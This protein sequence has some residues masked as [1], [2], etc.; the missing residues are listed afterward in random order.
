[1]LRRFALIAAL[2]SAL[3][4]GAADRPRVVVVK[5]AA[6]GPYAQVMAGFSAE[7]K[8]SVE[9][10]TL[11]EGAAAVEAAFKQVAQSKPALVLAVG[12]A[13]AV[14][15]RRQF[16]DVPVLFV[17]VP[18][19]Q[20]YELDGQNVTGIALTSDLSL[21]FAALK[22]TWPQTKRVGVL[23]DL[24]FSKK[25]LED[26]AV[27]AQAAGLVLVPLDLDS[28]QKVDKALGA[29]KGKVDALVIISDKTVGNAAVVERLLAFAQAEKVP[30]VGLVPSQVGRGALFALAPAPLAIGQQAGRLAN[31]ILVEKVDPGALAVVG[32]EGVELHVDLAQAEKLGARESFAA[33][34]LR[35]AAQRGLPVKAVE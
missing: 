25:Y 11:Q 12:P 24:R 3:S 20:K 23:A 35:F 32:P 10:V 33:E 2:L 21:E 1:M 22:A 9:E 27:V 34:V 17:M 30:A 19:F 13:A 14:G 15:A 29:A 26:A 28:P 7:A 4:A 6:L 31:R 8:A 16:S 5:S 18:Y